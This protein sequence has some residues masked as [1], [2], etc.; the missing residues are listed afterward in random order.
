LRP[1]SIGSRGSALALWQAEHVRRLLRERIG[2]DAT[3]I[4]IKTAG[5]RAV[6]VPFGRVGTK[7][8]FLK[9]LEDALLDGRI[10]LAVHSLKD[11]PTEMPA[12]L[13]LAA[14]LERDDVRDAL[15][16]RTGAKL[17]A[18]P[19]RARI[20]TSSLRRAS[21]LR[22]YRPNLGVAE[23]RGNVDTRLSKLDRGDYDAIVLAKAGLDRLGLSQR[24]TEILPAEISL[25][26]AGQGALTIEARADDAE[27]I[28]RVRKLDHAETRACVETERELLAALGGGCQIPVGA[29][30][31][32]EP[33]RGEDQQ[34]VLDAVV[35]SPDGTDYL[36]RQATG[37]ADRA[38]E[39][40][41]S[42]AA[43]LIADGAD[44]ILAQ[45][46]GTRAGSAP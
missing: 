41:R 44:R 45:G 37:R 17:D 40:G 34:L 8:M 6:D 33:A 46:G 29:W 25:P 39:L 28:D 5:D 42:L 36:R 22:H 11:V 1:L 38:R 43:D 15:V 19:P 16:S 35:L 2:A 9:E 10:D 31:R 13:T 21:Q 26:A 32:I 27:L 3:I 23:I 4:V 18:L 12:G 14:F 24:I 7:G 20:G 30:A